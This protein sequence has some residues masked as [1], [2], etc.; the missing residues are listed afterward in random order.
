M[1]DQEDNIAA[2]C[3]KSQELDEPN[4]KAMMDLDGQNAPNAETRMSVQLWLEYQLHNWVEHENI[5]KVIALFTA[6]VA[7]ASSKLK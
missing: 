7:E 2:V 3:S 6:L 5:Y 1:S 4:K